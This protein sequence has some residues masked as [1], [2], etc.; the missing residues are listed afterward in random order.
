MADKKVFVVFGAT[1][2][3]GGSVAAAL[4]D[5]GTFEVRAVTRDTS[6][7]AAVKLKE[8]GAEVVSADLDDEK[9]LEAALS[10]AYGAFLVTN[11]LEHFSK[12][13][14]ITQRTGE[15]EETDGGKLE[16]QNFDGKGEIE[17]YFREIGVPMTSVRL[18]CYY[19][20]LLTF[21]RP[22]KNKDGDGYSLGDNLFLIDEALTS[23]LENEDCF[24]A[25]PMGDVPLDKM[26]VKDLGGVVVSILKSPSEYI[27][28]NIGL[29]TEKLTVAQYAAIMSRVTGKDIKDAKITLEAFGNLGFPGAAELVNMFRFYITKPDR[30]V[31]ITLK[32][33]PK[34]KSFESWM[35][36]NKEAFKDL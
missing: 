9:S 24:L 36:E 7:P 15:C 22:Q 21:F 12:V 13:K 25:L 2:A 3:Q 16:V 4:L 6:K 1:G 8:A 20:N 32:L 30:D 14:E 29:S 31:D 23:V 33:N 19:E 10:G 28:K 18:P 35:E 27:G 5:D 26:S 11:F 34:A 17:E